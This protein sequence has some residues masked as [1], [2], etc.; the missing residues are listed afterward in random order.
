MMIAQALP[1]AV[2]LAGWLGS[3][4]FLVG[5][6]N[7][8]LKLVDRV[9]GR[10]ALPPNEVLG[11]SAQELTRRMVEA[12]RKIDESDKRR[13]ALY[14]R[15]ES[16]AN[17]MRTMVDALKEQVKAGLDGLRR[18]VKED[19][20]ALHEKIN[21]V[22]AGQSGHETAVELLNQRVAQIGSNIEQ[23]FQHLDEKLDRHWRAQ[24]GGSHES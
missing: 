8:L 11:Q 22:A 3:L 4:M 1:E 2:Q 12:E 7:G 5:L 17:A 23:R 9:K 21:S 19:T 6:L 13:K 20:D 18:E 10:P 16:S 14:D 15:I 24:S